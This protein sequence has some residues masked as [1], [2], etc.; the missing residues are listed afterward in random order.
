MLLLVE[1][2]VGVLYGTM[3]L[4]GVS[5]GGLL[6][7]WNALVPRLFGVANFGR[8][9]GWMGPVIALTTM[10]VY[11]AVGLVRDATESYAAVFQGDLVA[12]ALARAA[13]AP[14]E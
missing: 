9:M 2:G 6:P 14:A 10:S 3:A 7:V 4:L 5:T 13:G 8:A 11:P 12:L 1:P